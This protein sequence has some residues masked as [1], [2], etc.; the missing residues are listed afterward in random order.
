[1]EHNNVTKDSFKNACKASLNVAFEVILFQ[2]LSATIMNTKLAI[3]VLNQVHC[4]SAYFRLGIGHY[5]NYTP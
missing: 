2:N 5:E 1:M 4:W 3:H